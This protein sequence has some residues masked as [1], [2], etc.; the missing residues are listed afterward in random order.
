MHL[1]S[2]M[3]IL[4]SPQAKL[5]MLPKLFMELW[6]KACRNRVYFKM[7]Y[8]PVLLLFLPY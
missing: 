1:I 4:R 2:R 7:L 6:S 5:D 8:F 3:V